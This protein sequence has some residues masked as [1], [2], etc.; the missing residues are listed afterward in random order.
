M[1]TLRLC[2]KLAWDEA[3]SSYG[4]RTVF[5]EQTMRI[6]KHELSGSKLEAPVLQPMNDVRRR[7]RNATIT[8]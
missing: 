5:L 3:A 1:P 4:N 2:L 8:G 6:Q 7:L